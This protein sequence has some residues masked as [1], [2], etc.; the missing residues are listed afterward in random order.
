M[1]VTVSQEIASAL[2]DPFAKPPGLPARRLAVYRNNVATSLAGAMKAQF[3]AVARLLGDELFSRT[4][5]AYVRAEPPR[6]VLLFEIGQGF[7]SFLDLDAALARYPFVADVARLEYAMALAQH[8]VDATPIDSSSLSGPTESELTRLGF[9]WHP[10]ARLFESNFPA[11]S[12]C[13]QNRDGGEP[14]PISEWQGE[15]ALITRPAMAVTVRS[16]PPGGFAFL[17]AV[18]AGRPFPVAAERGLAADSAFD[19]AA[20]IAG[21]FAAG[22][23]TGLRLLPETK[24]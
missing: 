19:L 1:N 7:G 15:A 17:S 5:L 3:P 11:V 13:G 9:A 20:N 12:I 8:A 4:A 10:A 18:R 23:I 6:S 21:M 16:L 14:V 22:A 2:L 24:E